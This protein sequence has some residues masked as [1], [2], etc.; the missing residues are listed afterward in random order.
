MESNKKIRR[1]EKKMEKK[2]TNEENGTRN[3]CKRGK[4]SEENSVNGVANVGEN[5]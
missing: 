5:T 2:G 3:Y 4:A 1:S